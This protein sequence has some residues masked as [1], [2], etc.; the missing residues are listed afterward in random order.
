[1]RIKTSEMLLISTLPLVTTVESSIEINHKYSPRKKTN[2]HNIKF[3]HKVRHWLH[4]YHSSQYSD[5][6]RSY[7]E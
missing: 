7:Y 4:F 1:M 3:Q 2:L 5:Y 6:A